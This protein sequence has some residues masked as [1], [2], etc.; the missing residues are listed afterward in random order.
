[1]TVYFEKRSIDLFHPVTL[2]LKQSQPH[3]LFGH[4]RYSLIYCIGHNTLTDFF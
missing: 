3:V 1:M 4:I 2:S